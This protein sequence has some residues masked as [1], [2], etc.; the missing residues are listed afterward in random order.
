MSELLTEATARLTA[1][2][3]LAEQGLAVLE[4][5]APERRERL[6]DVR[7]VAVFLEREYPALLARWDGHERGGPGELQD[8]PGSAD[9]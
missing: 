4:G 1:F 5:E 8:R 6:Q 3:R 9:E 2:R 7:A